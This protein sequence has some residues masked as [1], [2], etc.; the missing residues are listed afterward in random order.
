MMEMAFAHLG[1]VTISVDLTPAGAGRRSGLP[2]RGAILPRLLE[3]FDLYEIPAT[4]AAPE[5]AEAEAVPEILTAQVPHEIALLGNARWVGAAAGRPHF[6]GELARRVT[7]ARAAGLDIHALLVSQVCVPREHY[8]LLVKQQL[9]VVRQPRFG[10][11]RTFADLQ[12][13]A[14]RHG[15]WESPAVCVIPRTAP[16]WGRGAASARAAVRKAIALQGVA[17]VAFDAA[18]LAVHDPRLHAA[19]SLLCY[20]ARGCGRGLVRTATLSRSAEEWSQPSAATPARSILR[21]A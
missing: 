16:I 7:A 1:A 11:K 4:W 19:E 14:L 15:L 8:D 18:A 10:V 6:A 9:T 5:P 21:A 12:P 3:L 2:L 20:V 17:H 13:Q